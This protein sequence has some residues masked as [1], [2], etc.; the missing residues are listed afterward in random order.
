MKIVDE[1]WMCHLDLHET[2]DTDSTEFT[3]AKHAEAGSIYE[4]ETIPD[5]FY[6]VG[7]SEN[8]GGQLDFQEAVINEVRKVRCKWQHY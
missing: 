8:N 7:D 2:T 1:Q 4:G 6:L 3:P 5:G